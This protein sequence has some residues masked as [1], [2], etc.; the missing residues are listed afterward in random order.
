VQNVAVEHLWSDF[1]EAFS[2]H[3]ILGHGEQKSSSVRAGVIYLRK[4]ETHK[5]KGNPEQQIFFV[6]TRQNH[7]ETPTLVDSF[8][9]IPSCRKRKFKCYK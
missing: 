1:R 2:A 4:R 9:L 8:C 7:N 6:T 5:A 3:T